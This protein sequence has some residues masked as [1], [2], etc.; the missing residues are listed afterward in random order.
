MTSIDHPR[1]ATILVEKGARPGTTRDPLPRLLA[2]LG[3]RAGD[4]G[5]IIR[6]TSRPWASALFQGRRHIVTMWIGGDDAP[7][8]Q[9][10]F[11]DGL[12]EVQWSLPN[13]FVA[14]IIIDD[15]APAP[16]EGIE[17]ELSILTIE[18]W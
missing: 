8:R 3:A 10:R 7:A 9:T 11:A 6:A 13:H 1:T 16:E 2:Q 4:P 15:V 14:D 18:D 5:R 17:M 12:G